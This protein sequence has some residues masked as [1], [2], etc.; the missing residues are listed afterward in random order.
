ML[1]HFPC[2]PTHRTCPHGHVL[3]ARLPPRPHLFSH[4]P[5]DTK[6][7]RCVACFSCSAAPLPPPAL[8][9]Q[10]NTKT[11]P[12]GHILRAR[13]PPPLY[14]ILTRN[15][16]PLRRVFRGRLPPH[17]P[18]NTK[19]CPSGHVFVLAC[20]ATFD[21]SQTQKTRPYGAFFVFGCSLLNP[22]TSAPNTIHGHVF[23]A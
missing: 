3:C 10:P 11:C 8:S 23:V 4:H 6:N 14:C 9:L 15:T 16:R 13:L 7:A 1:E 18:T 22:T 2:S 17:P 21:Y 20:L 12:C 19:T 5:Q